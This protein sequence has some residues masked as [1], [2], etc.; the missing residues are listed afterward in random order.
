MRNEFPGYYRPSEQE[1][2]DLWEQALIVT[3]A[4]VLLTLY[5]LGDTTRERLLEILRKLEQR[6][7]LPYQAGYEFQRTA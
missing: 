6:L 7:F 2:E 1:F 4:N 3:D 5:R